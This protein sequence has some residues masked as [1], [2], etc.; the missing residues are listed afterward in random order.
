MDVADSLVAGNTTTLIS[1]TWIDQ[2]ATPATLSPLDEMVAGIPGVRGA[3]LASVDGF[4]IASS[5]TLSDDPAHAAML[6]ATL[7]VGNQI[8]ALGNG[9]AVRQLV[10]DHD[11]GLIIVRPLGQARVLAVVADTN[12]DQIQL[13]VT[14][15]ARARELLEIGA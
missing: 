6:A 3:M 12:L 8:I 13:G 2:A 10:I 1:T 9:S 7:G 11:G 4:T 15:Q 14:V 5:R